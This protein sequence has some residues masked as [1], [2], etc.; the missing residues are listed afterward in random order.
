MKKST[1][2]KITLVVVGL[3]VLVYFLGEIG[4]LGGILTALG[5]GSSHKFKE[6]IKQLDKEAEKIKA[7]VDDL[8]EKKKNLEV[9]DKTDQ[10]EVDYW[11]G[12]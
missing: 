3:S 1:I 5:L 9:E 12:E 6:K 4:L 2:I 8:E 10:E 7:E 11:K